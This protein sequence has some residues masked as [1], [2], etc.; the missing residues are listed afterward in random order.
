M[1]VSLRELGIK[2]EELEL[3]AEKCSFK[4]TRTIKGIVEI[5]KDEM[6]AIYRLAMKGME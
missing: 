6:L 2:E 1:P 4:R 5:G 3:L